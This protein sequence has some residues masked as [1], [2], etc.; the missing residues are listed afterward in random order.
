VPFLVLLVGATWGGLR[1][2]K[3]VE[4]LQAE[5]AIVM[6]EIHKLRTLP[7]ARIHSLTDDLARYNDRGR[8]IC[9]TGGGHH[10]RPQDCD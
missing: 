2:R 8:Y 3:Q 4:V 6:G 9:A 5:I 7:A 10:G 1:L